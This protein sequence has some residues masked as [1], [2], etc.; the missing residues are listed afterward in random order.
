MHEQSL[1]Q[2]LIYSCICMHFLEVTHQ[3]NVRICNSFCPEL[4]RNC[5][6]ARS[7]FVLCYYTKLLQTSMYVMTHEK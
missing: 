4:S 7:A 5:K 2:I 1:C 3:D 6:A